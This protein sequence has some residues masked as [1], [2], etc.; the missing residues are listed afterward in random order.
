M[1]GV[2]FCLLKKMVVTRL[3]AEAWD[4]LVLQTKLQTVGGE[5]LG[6]VTYPDADLDALLSTAS[7]ATGRTVGDLLRAFGRFVFPDLV[8]LDPSFAP[9]GTDAKSFLRRVDSLI[10]VEVHKA[11]PGAKLPYFSYEDPAPDRLVMLYRSP[12][13]LCDLVAGFIEGTADYFGEGIAQEHTQCQRD[14]D[15]ACRF[16]LQFSSGEG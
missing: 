11:H 14:G 9:H 7:E 6:S 12:R 8:A 1:K 3:G 5:F 2:I 16:E 10:H 15:H 4:A 13:G